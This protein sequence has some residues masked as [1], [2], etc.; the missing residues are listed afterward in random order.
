MDIEERIEQLRKMAKANPDDD[1]AHFA[2][3]QALVDS[4]R[5]SEAVPVL[6][7]VVKI[8][9]RYTR[10]YLLLGIAL[11]KD[12]DEDGGIEAW[13]LGYHAAQNRGEL[14]VSREIETQLKAKNAPLQSE[15]V[16]LLGIEE[17]KESISEQRAL[18][19]DELICLKSGKIGKKM[20]FDPFNDQIGAFIYQ[21]IS[22]E[23]WEA[24]MEMSIKVINELRLDLGDP[25]GQIQYEQNMKTFLNLP[26]DLFKGRWS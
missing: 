3:G 20:K 26:E 25:D 11:D 17:P 1:L 16:D 19:A 13:Q 6:K 14:M 10:A 12:G 4:D 24:W 5:Y 9:P 15:I 8:N 7:H 22:Q 2:L 18:E 21:N 23:S